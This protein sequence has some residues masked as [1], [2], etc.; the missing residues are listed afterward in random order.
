MFTDEEILKALDTVVDGKR[1]Y[2]YEA[3][4]NTEHKR[5]T[6]IIYS[7]DDCIVGCVIRELDPDLHAQILEEERAKG[8]SWSFHRTSDYAD[9][10]RMP[11]RNAQI[12]A[13]RRGQRFQ[14]EG[15][16]WGEAARAIREELG[17]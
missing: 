9:G 4:C 14:D 7:Y 5:D 17:A 16:A 15:Q 10:I 3:N 1:D 2:V 12:Q 13:L 11:F 8:T 6:G